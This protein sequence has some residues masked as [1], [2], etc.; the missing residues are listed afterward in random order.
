MTKRHNDYEPLPDTDPCC[1]LFPKGV[2]A[3]VIDGSLLQGLDSYTVTVLTQIMVDYREVGIDVFL[4]ECKPSVLA[5]LETSGI[6][7]HVERSQV[8]DT[9][10]KAVT[11][12]LESCA[13]CTSPPP[14]NLLAD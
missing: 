12:A 1:P 3:I 8:R 14:L 2:K 7:D 6:Y 5:Q 4:A 10:H 9:F 11:Q 13:D